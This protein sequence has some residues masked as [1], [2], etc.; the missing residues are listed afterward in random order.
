MKLQGKLTTTK[1]EFQ[2]WLNGSH[3]IIPETLALLLLGESIMLK[4]DLIPRGLVFN[5]LVL[6]LTE[7][8]IRDS[9]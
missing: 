9:C 6:D 2:E 3:D 8:Y 5:H 1:P 4:L 7:E